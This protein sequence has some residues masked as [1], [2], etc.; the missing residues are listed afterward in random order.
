MKF[1]FS[2]H[3][4][5]FYFILNAYRKLLGLVTYL[6]WIMIIVTTIS[7]MSMMAET[8]YKRVNNTNELKVCEYIFFVA[9]SIE[10]GLKILAN[11]FFFTPKAVIK[12]FGGLLDLFIYIVSTFYTLLI[13]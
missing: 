5:G 8:P 6:D 11:G 12:D 13:D 1:L 7:C 9:M 10:M 4:V 2:F 3:F